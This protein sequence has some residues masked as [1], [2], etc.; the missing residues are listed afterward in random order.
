MNPVQLR[1]SAEEEKKEEGDSPVK[2]VKL[3]EDPDEN[4]LKRDY[5]VVDHEKCEKL[6]E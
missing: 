3:E 4:K 5:I 2:L 6:K 1:L